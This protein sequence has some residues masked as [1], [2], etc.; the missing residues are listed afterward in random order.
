[1][2]FFSRLFKPKPAPN[3]RRLTGETV[4]LLLRSALAG[5]L[6]PNYRHVGAKRMMAVT[7]REMVRAASDRSFKPWSRDAWE[8]EDQARALVNDLQL[9]AA[10]EGCSHAAGVLIGLRADD[11]TPD[12][13]Q[14]AHV[15]VWAIIESVG[16]PRVVLFDATEREWT[17][18]PDVCEIHIST[19]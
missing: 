13:R 3:R 12:E 16:E 5:R 6:A 19:T 4:A 8:C 7:T 9:L 10:I 11:P 17:D 1:M 2:S 18:I 15:W 14:D